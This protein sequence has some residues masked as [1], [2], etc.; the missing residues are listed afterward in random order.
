MEISISKEVLPSLEE[1]GFT[2]TLLGD[3]RGSIRQYRN[4]GGLHVLEYHD[5]FVVHEDEVDPRVDPVGHLIKDSPE[6]LFALGAAYLL[7]QSHNGVSSKSSRYVS[8]SPLVFILSFL[9][10][11]RILGLIKRFL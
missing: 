7:S 8:F 11:N 3:A 1:N 6:T 10:L 9:S 5:K 4:S 2:E